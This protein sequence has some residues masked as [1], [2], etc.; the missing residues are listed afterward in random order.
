MKEKNE[1]RNN[2]QE[3]SIG[4]IL[5]ISLCRIARNKRGFFSLGFLI[6]VAVMFLNLGS[7]ILQFSDVFNKG[8]EK[9]KGAHITYLFDTAVYSERFLDPVKN[10]DYV[11]RIERE[12]LISL[13]TEK[14]I[15]PKGQK[16]TAKKLY[17]FKFNRDRKVSTVKLTE[18]VAGDPKK[19][20]YLP[21]NFKAGGYKLGG[22][23]HFGSP[24]KSYDL[25]ILGFYES[26]QGDEFKYSPL[27]LM[28][29]DE[30]YE[31]LALSAKKLVCIKLRLTKVEDASLAGS[32]GDH[33]SAVSKSSMPYESVVLYSNYEMNTNMIWS[34]IGIFALGVSIVLF[35]ISL[36][37]IYYR[38]DEGIEQGMLEI[39]TLGALGYT[40]GTIRLAYILEY[41]IVGTGASVIGTAGAYGITKI[42][43]DLLSFYGV[44][45]LGFHLSM[46]LLIILLV[47][48]FVIGILLLVTH[49]LD[50]YS[51]IVAFRLGIKNHSFKKDHLPMENWMGS[52]NVILAGKESL[53]NFRKNLMIGLIMAFLTLI[54]SVCGILYYN[55]SSNPG[56]LKALVGMVIPDA[57]LSVYD[58]QDLSEIMDELRKTKGVKSLV[59]VNNTY[60]QIDKT[61]CNFSSSDELAL[62]GKDFLSRG[63]FP[64]YENEV[65][66]HERI[67]RKTG[68]TVGDGIM[69][70]K[71]GVSKKYII[72]G[73][74][75]G[76][77]QSNFMT[78]EGMELLDKTTKNLVLNINLEK[79]MAV[80]ELRAML[81]K[82]YGIGG[83]AD[84]KDEE[85]LK[86]LQEKVDHILQEAKDKGELDG[87]E[88]ALM[89]NGE[90]ILR[91]NTYGNKI[92]EFRDQ[93][94]DIMRSQGQM[95][96][97]IVFISGLLSILVVIIIS[98][99]LGIII[100]ALIIDRRKEFGIHMAVG[101]TSRQLRFQLAL[102][103]LPAVLTGLA[104]GSGMGIL[105]AKPFIMALISTKGFANLP[106][107][108]NNPTIVVF[109]MAL[110]IYVYVFALWEA[111]KIKKIPVADMMREA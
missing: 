54:L 18:K 39:G 64:K 81:D 44:N 97:M 90:I 104:L 80:A 99:I 94:E 103:L 74:T 75:L 3:M 100:K 31:E 38:I 78:N 11:E 91:S 89:K 88:I 68:K 24:E 29:A 87:G 86:T 7:T 10:V 67:A 9:H 76:I 6:F 50:Q 27:W 66:I 41:I 95:G 55:F 72:T 21:K 70:S 20:V 57:S 107:L 42:L 102:S 17:L 96:T 106:I 34:F 16:N 56:V 2:G 65:A 40:T 5:W 35:L 92:M 77:T 63:R 105:F 98:V 59:L 26:W 25:P 108:V 14:I 52:V 37:V 32:I 61:W 69:I 49:K 33:A 47:M 53:M 93:R 110:G 12:T 109:S 62:V 45:S 4:T 71:S 82:K 79:T 83:S 111:R 51:P 23:F 58:N 30:T 19:G 15:S 28:L 13:P 73:T 84:G 43:T 48:S 22:T 8:F 36:V 1:M 46:D 85:G 101:Y 60:L